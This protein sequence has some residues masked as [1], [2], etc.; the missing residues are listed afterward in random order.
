M[1]HL[2]ERWGRRSIYTWN[3]REKCNHRFWQ[4]LK[5][6][7]IAQW[8]HLH[9]SGVSQHEILQELGLLGLENLEISL[10]L[11]DRLSW[12]RSYWL[13]SSHW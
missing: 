5:C 3:Q 1:L 9:Q 8:F 10:L 2:I 6:R 7:F 4:T 12:K 11:G 13:T